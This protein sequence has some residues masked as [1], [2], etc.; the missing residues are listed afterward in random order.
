[1]VRYRSIS[2]KILLPYL[3]FVIL[4]KLPVLVRERLLFVVLLLL[5]DIVD[6]HLLVS[7]RVGE[8]SK[9]FRPAVKTGEMRILLQPGTGHRLNRL[10]KPSYRQQGGQF[11]KKMYMVRHPAYTQQFDISILAHTMDERVQLLLVLLV[12][13]A[14]SAISAN[15][16]VIVKLCVAHSFVFFVAGDNA[17][18]VGLLCYKVADAITSHFR[19]RLP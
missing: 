16:N 14:F 3:H 13:S 10:D 4:Q 2:E 8:S 5:S 1:M 6:Y 19:A 15:D 7:Y 9:L 12:D 11:D 17:V 18:I